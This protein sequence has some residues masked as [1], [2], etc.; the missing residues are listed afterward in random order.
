MKINFKKIWSVVTFPFRMIGRALKAAWKWAR[1]KIIKVPASE[2][3][4]FLMSLALILCCVWIGTM[5]KLVETHYI[6]Q[7]KTKIIQEQAKTIETYKIKE[8]TV[9]VPGKVRIVTTDARQ[10]QRQIAAAR[11]EASELRREKEHYQ[12]LARKYSRPA[13][14]GATPAQRVQTEEHI[15]DQFITDWSAKK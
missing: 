14:K 9:R 12:E 3:E 4:A 6:I 2:A 11:H 1:R 8:R 5:G 10:L 7:E 13:P 15:N